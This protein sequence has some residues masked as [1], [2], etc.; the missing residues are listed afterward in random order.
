MISERLQQEIDDFCAKK[1][2]NLVKVRK[3]KKGGGAKI[4]LTFLCK[5]CN[6][7]FDISWD[8]VRR[9]EYPG[10]CVKCCFLRRREKKREGARGL[11]A[12]F[13]KHG[14]HVTTPIDKIKP[15]GKKKSYLKTKVSIVDDNGNEYKDINLAYFLK[16]ILKK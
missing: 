5:D 4:V 12:K 3:I 13:E 7:R 15:R 16:N 2:L 10:C 6:R 14:Y 11:M 9:Q 1:E 8:T